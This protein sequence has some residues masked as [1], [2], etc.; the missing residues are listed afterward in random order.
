MHI[1]LFIYFEWVRERSPS[2]L[3]FENLQNVFFV[4]Y[5]ATATDFEKK[6]DAVVTH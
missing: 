4:Y 1:V 5:E 3:L 6:I 2:S